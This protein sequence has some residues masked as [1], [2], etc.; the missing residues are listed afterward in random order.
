MAPA[1]AA[2]ALS[3]PF[4]LSPHFYLCCVGGHFLATTICTMLALLTM[5][6]FHFSSSVCFINFLF[7]HNRSI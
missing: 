3:V 1:A 5:S 6:V 2:V 7:I 4:S